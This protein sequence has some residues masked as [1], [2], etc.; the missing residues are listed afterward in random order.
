MICSGLA[1]VEQP[2]GRADFGCSLTAD[3]SLALPTPPLRSHLR[4]LMMSSFG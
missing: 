1:S 4:L 2:F 3:C